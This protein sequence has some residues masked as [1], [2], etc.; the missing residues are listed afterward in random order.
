MKLAGRNEKSYQLETH[1]FSPLSAVG[2]C[3]DK[4]R[5]HSNIESSLSK[6][7]HHKED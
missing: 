4:D 5:A 2:I 3:A 1:L 7:L 6:K